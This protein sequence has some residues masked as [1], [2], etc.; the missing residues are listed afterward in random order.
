MTDPETKTLLDRARNDDAAAA[1]E[2]FRRHR[3]RLATGLRRKYRAGAG[4]PDD[5][6]QDAV[7]LAFRN[8][9]RFEYRGKGSFLAWL[10]SC[11]DLEFR[12]AWRH[13][14]ADKR[15]EGR[16]AAPPATGWAPP[17]AGPS[18]S[19]AVRGAEL[20]ERLR[21]LIDEL[22]EREREAL[23]LRR[24]LGLDAEAIRVELELPSAGA[25][26]ALLSRAQVRLAERLGD[27]S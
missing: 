1:D 18:P 15:D 21:R 22:P 9:S 8:L 20:G 17:D 27:G 26:R 24:F 11:A 2:L 6:V 5:L 10:F 19:E 23:V 13:A 12:R 3:A 25:A 14:H 16:N 7:L 4:E